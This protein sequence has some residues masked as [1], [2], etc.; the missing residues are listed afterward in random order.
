[1]IRARFVAIAVF[2]TVFEKEMILDQRGDHSFHLGRRR[3]VMR[4]VQMSVNERQ[5]LSGMEGQQDV[6]EASMADLQGGIGASCGLSTLTVREYRVIRV[7]PAGVS[8]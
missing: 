2:C 8:C 6:L 7:E 5:F 4:T 1:M 3:D